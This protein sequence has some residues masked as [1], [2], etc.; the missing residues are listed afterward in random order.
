MKRRSKN[1]GKVLATE[2]AA[3]GFLDT[4]IRF[5]HMWDVE[6]HQANRFGVKS[7]VEICAISLCALQFFLEFENSRDNHLWSQFVFQC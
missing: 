5:L 7:L 1:V 6:V 3:A 2:K 4:H